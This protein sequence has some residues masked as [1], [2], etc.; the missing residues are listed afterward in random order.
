MVIMVG[1][2]AGMR[3]HVE[4]DVK[5]EKALAEMNGAELR[6]YNMKRYEAEVDRLNRQ[7]FREILAQFLACAPEP[8]AIM[9]HARKSPDRWAQAVSILA[10]ASGFHDKIEHE[11][12]VFVNI[13]NMSDAELELEA[14][15]GAKELLDGR[16]VIEGEVV[17]P[18]AEPGVEDPPKGA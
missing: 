12:N 9:E 2:F 1:V 3:L 11:H 18:P 7:P 16:K 8:E 14:R 5:P 10:K 15:K 17:G 4:P 6:A 13:Q